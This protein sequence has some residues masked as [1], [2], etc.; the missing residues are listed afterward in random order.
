MNFF[1]R[2]ISDQ[3]RQVDGVIISERMKSGSSGRGFREMSRSSKGLMEGANEEDI[4]D[5]R[6]EIYGN[7]L[8]IVV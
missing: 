5:G 4:G 6:E 1:I 2:Q 7:L 3:N 8:L